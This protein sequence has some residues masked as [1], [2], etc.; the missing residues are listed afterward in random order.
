MN[1]SWKY[2]VTQNSTYYTWT[3]NKWKN[4]KNE[5][6]KLCGLNKLAV[7]SITPNFGLW[8]K[9]YPQN[10]YKEAGQVIQFDTGHDEKLVFLSF[11]EPVESKNFWKPLIY[12]ESL[13]ENQADFLKEKEKS[14]SH[15]YYGNLKEFDTIASNGMTNRYPDFI[16]NIEDKNFI[17]K[18]N[19]IDNVL[20]EIIFY[21]NFWYYWAFNPVYMYAF[22][23]IWTKFYPQN[24]L[25]LDKYEPLDNTSWL[26]QIELLKE[27]KWVP[28]VTR[29]DSR[30]KDHIEWT[31]T[32]LSRAISYEK[33]KNLYSKL[34]I[35]KDF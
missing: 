28:V 7:Q 19:N 3:S 35:N 22:K 24:V 5:V 10:L 8:M 18:I 11:S 12:I 14:L 21:K 32:I 2:L 13:F 16:A 1:I 27:T 6:I 26:I 30:I 31:K 17:E 9:K 20:E 15:F 34:V 33:L 23:K 4:E 25:D 29:V